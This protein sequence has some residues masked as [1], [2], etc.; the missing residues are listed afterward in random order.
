MLAGGASTRMGRPKEALILD[1]ETMLER[2]IRLLGAV[3]RSVAVVGR[4]A[5]APTDVLAFADELTGRGPL[6]GISTGLWRTRT[7]F[8]LFLG[9][10]MPFMAA[11]F[12][13]YLGERALESRAGVTVPQTPGRGYQPLCAVYRREARAAVQAALA[14]GRNKVTSF[15]PKVR[16][17]RIQWAEIARAGF[18]L[19]IFENMNTPA[20]YD[21]VRRRLPSWCGH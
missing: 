9:C 5:Q 15:Y 12:L 20:D 3:C 6:G 13:S 7:E 11:R 8:N 14:A 2:Q 18:G 19:R 4:P 21:A 17:R 1:G 16:V 10:D